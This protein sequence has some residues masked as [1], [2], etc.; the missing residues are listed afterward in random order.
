MTSFIGITGSVAS[1]KSTMAARLATFLA[2]D[3]PSMIVQTVCTDAF[4]YP[5]EKLA[6]LGLSKKKGFPES[7]DIEALVQFLSKIKQGGS[8]VLAPRYSH[9][10]YDIVPDSYQSIDQPDLLIVEGLNVLSERLVNFF[11]L[12][13]YLHAEDEVLERW[14]I[15]R[16][17]RLCEE[18]RY[19][20]NTYFH[21]YA[22]WKS[23]DLAR[24]ASSV[25]HE[26]NLPNL[27]QYI[28]PAKEKA[29]LVLN[30]AS[31]H[32]FI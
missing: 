23:E 22:E 26:I 1:G 5:N 27:K 20:P 15:E 11:D 31:D 30:K 7:Y 13:I 19:N 18:G 24:Y 14:Y 2:E 32:T 29:H 28:L 9:L 17:L 10:S 25:W 4:L 16:F 21:R 3:K 8:P 12:S 6:A